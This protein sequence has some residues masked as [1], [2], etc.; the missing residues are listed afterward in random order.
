M[1]TWATKPTSYAWRAQQKAGQAQVAKNREASPQG[2]RVGARQAV[3]PPLP[4]HS[5]LLLLLLLLL[6]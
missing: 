2:H 3:H 4:C 6:L 1:P 5:D